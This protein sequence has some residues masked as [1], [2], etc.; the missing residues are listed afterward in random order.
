MKPAITIPEIH[1]SVSKLCIMY[2]Q[3]DYLSLPDVLEA[4]ERKI[5]VESSAY[6]E[7]P[8]GFAVQGN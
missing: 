6:S 8:T 2:I 1:S 7:D 5:E 4:Q 3:A